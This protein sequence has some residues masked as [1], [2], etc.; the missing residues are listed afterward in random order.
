MKSM[1]DRKSMNGHTCIYREGWVNF[2]ARGTLSILCHKYFFARPNLKKNFANSNILIIF[3]ILKK[4][5]KF[6]YAISPTLS[7][8][9]QEQCFNPFLTTLRI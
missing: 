1:N 2:S 6:K 5:C 8:T 7:L 4:L 3:Q 9:M